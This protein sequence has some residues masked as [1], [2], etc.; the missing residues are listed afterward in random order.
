MGDALRTLEVVAGVIFD[1]R[2]E[3][4]LLS[5]RKPHQDQGDRWEFPGGKR[6][7]GETLEAALVR[8]LQEELGIVAERIGFRTTLS[9]RYPDKIVQLSVFDVT[10]F[11]GLPEGLEHQTLRWVP[12]AEL[13]GLPFPDANR[14]IVDELV[15]GAGQQVPGSAR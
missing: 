15:R 3:R 9:H 10:G 13:A 1:R 14:G 11:S 6:E 2:A 7:A 8:E 12:I 4:V 5:L